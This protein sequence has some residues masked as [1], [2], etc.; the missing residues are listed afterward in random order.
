MSQAA[1][2]KFDAHGLIP[3]VIQDAE[4]R[5]VLMMAYMNQHSLAETLRTG[6][7]HFWSRSRGKLWLKGETS[8]HVQEVVSIHKNCY[9]D[10]LLIK[11]RQVGATCH[12]GYTSCFFRERTGDGKWQITAE[13]VF[14]PAEVYGEQ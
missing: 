5:E 10:C 14:D 3:A 13:R 1:E 6:K 8:G 12:M 7:T 11:V 2:L 9:S 4:T